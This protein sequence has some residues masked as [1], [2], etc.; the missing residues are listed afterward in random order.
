MLEKIDTIIISLAVDENQSLF[1]LLGLDGVIQCMGDGSVHNSD[2]TIYIGKT[3]PDL[4]ANLK[5]HINPQWLQ[6]CG[7]YTVPQR[8][9]QTCE[10]SIVFK[11]KENEKG[12]Q[13]V[14]G[15]T[16]QGPPT[17]ITNFVYF[18]V[19]LITPWHARQKHKTQSEGVDN[20]IS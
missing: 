8:C 2:K 20:G 13:F 19:D 15:A 17:D 11:A 5:Q 7:R 16:S 1:I 14:Y 6:R 4:F 3:S 9:G 18:A 12:I 10:L